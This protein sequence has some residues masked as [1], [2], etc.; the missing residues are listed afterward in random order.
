MLLEPKILQSHH[1]DD[2][3]LVMRLLFDTYTA[4]M[5][6]TTIFVRNSLPIE[7]VEWK[8]P[9][10][11]EPLT[12][13]EASKNEKLRRWADMAYR[14]TIRAQACDIL[15]AYLPA[16][17]LTNV[18][19]FGVGQ[20]FEHL[21]NKLYSHTLS[22]V[23]GIA[24]GIH[25]SLSQLIP[26]FVKRARRS[27]YLAETYTAARTIAAQVTERVSIAPS[28]PVTLVD[29]DDQAEAK[30]LAAILY[31]HTQHPLPQL[32]QLVANLPM[33]TKAQILSEYL[34]RRRHRRDKPGRAL[35]NVY[36]TFD[37]VGNLGLYRD[38]HR[39][40]IL[41]QERQDFTTT[42]GYDTAEE[43]EATGF[44][45]DFDRCMEAA[46]QLYR[47][48]V[49]DLPHEAQYVVPFAYR[50]RWY[51][52]MNLREAVHIGELRTM[53]QGHSDY[54]LI[55]QGMWKQITA[56]HPTLARAAAFIDWNT[57]RLGRLQSE[58]RNEY[59]KAAISL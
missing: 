16:A 28:Q 22:E 44:R 48:I 33:E 43:L 42:H 49:Q 9:Q 57:Y 59:K 40:R 46:D 53:P 4:Q 24:S 50:V 26:S 35:E 20:A 31:P 10:T 58:M 6:P 27:E 7:T 3:L 47:R 39:H 32:R 37:I 21:L 8:H 54:R 17:T 34:Q 11:G 51:M 45:S 2:Y 25:E 12:Y 52:K 29:Y 38:L 15:R 19:L 56:V 5:E 13:K 23:Q 14:S 41:T 36:Y 18:G 1:R 55:A 30:I